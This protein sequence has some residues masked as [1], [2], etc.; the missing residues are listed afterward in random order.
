MVGGRWADWSERA[1]TN[2]DGSLIASVKFLQ[3]TGVVGVRGEPIRHAFALQA[4]IFNTVF[5]GQV[6]A[7][8]IVVWRPV[9]WP[10][11]VW[12]GN[13]RERPCRLGKV[14]RWTWRSSVCHHEWTEQ[15]GT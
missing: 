10:N 3:H 4:V 7:N 15:L 13:G 11:D 1:D 14:A 6:P 9:F 12:G 5:Y 8:I 2:S